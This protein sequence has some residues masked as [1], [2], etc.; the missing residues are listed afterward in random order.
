EFE[1]NESWGYNPSFYFAPDKYYG[2]ANDLKAFIDS[3][4]NRGIAV[5]MDMVL[6]HSY[7]QSPLVQLYWDKAQGRPSADNPWYNVTSPNPVYSWGYDFDHTS[8]ATKDFVDRVN[9]YW[10]TEYNI[11]GFRFDFTKGFTN[12]PGD[13]SSYDPQRISILKRMADEIWKVKPGAYVILEHFAPNEEEKSLANYG[14]MIW[15]NHNY[16]YNE[17]TMGWTEDG[18]SD[19]SWISYQNRNWAYPNLVG[20]MESHDEERLMYKNLMWGNE[21][22]EYD[23]K[24]LEVALFRIELAAAFF[25]TIPGPKMIWQFGEM[26]YDYSIDFNGRVG[27]K[28]I[29]WDYYNSRTRLR[30][31]F[32]KFIKL[33]LNEP[34]F[35]TDNFTLDVRNGAKRIELNHEEMDVRIIGNFDVKSLPLYPNFSRTGEWYEY[36]SDE[37]IQVDDVNKVFWLKGGEYRVFTTKKL[38]AGELPTHTLFF[39]AED[40]F[41]VYPNPASEKIYITT[42]SRQLREVR[43]FDISGRF[44]YQTFANREETELDISGLDSGIYLVNM[45]DS[46]GKTFIRKI[47]KH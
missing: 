7:G 20:Y 4:H 3:C 33:K 41:L 32:S 39:E 29:R 13:G 8:Q 42:P 30:T 34:A 31:I 36:I 23:I 46:E 26:G 37:T 28:P 45:I 9:R 17:A 1:G 6:N 44:L 22:W 21:Y 47:I 18:K 40:D 24:D 12:T 15:G 5:I 25:F 19:F 38:D 27:N 10:L 11:D 35:S 16:N 14:M 2:P 43:L